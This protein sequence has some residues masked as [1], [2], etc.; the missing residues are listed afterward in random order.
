MN[1]FFFGTFNCKADAK[2]RIMLPIALRK[3]MESVLKEGFYVK[4]SYYKECLELY[5]AQEWIKINDELD[6]K[7]RYDEEVDD[8]IRMFTTGL[9]QVDLDNTGRL[10][11]PKDVM[12]MANIKKEVKISPIR[13]HLEIWDIETYNQAIAATKERKKELANKVMLGKTNEDVS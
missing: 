8:F 13:K 10:L 9:R 11:I 3:Q 2:G 1:I 7:S 4:K 5:P 12:A 6:E